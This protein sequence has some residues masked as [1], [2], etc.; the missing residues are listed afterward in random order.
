LA[1]DTSWRSAVDTLSCLWIHREDAAVV[2][3]GMTGWI[4]EYEPD[5]RTQQSAKSNPTGVLIGAD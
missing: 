1:S 3:G 4:E 2:C 5:W